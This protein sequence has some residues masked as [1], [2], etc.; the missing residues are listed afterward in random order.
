MIRKRTLEYGMVVAG[1]VILILLAV[2]HLPSRAIMPLDEKTLEKFQEANGRINAL[3]QSETN[4]LT[5]VEIN[6]AS[7]QE[8]VKEI[9]YN[10]EKTILHWLSPEFQAEVRAGDPAKMTDTLR[11]TDSL[12]GAALGDGATSEE[13]ERIIGRYSPAVQDAARKRR[14]G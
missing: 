12:L 11:L 5:P 4:G 8:A 13:F 1:A 7:F 14:G 10:P 2:F 6:A 3:R 9:G